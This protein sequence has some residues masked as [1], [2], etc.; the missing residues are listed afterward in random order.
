MMIDMLR[1]IEKKAEPAA[2]ADRGDLA[3]V[4][5]SDLLSDTVGQGE[6]ESTLARPTGGNPSEVA[7]A[8]SSGCPALPCCSKRWCWRWPSR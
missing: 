6:A 2:A 8:T 4:Q 3:N 1:D 5:P 7:R